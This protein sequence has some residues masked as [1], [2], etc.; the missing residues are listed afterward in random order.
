MV[1]FNIHKSY[2]PAIKKKT[3]TEDDFLQVLKTCSFAVAKILNDIPPTLKALLPEKS[4][5]NLYGQFKTDENMIN[6]D[7]LY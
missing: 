6:L 4:P 3:F 5:S 2:Y 1:Y 7:L